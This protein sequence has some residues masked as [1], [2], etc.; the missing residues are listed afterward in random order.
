V[1]RIAA[2]LL[3]SG[4]LL[5]AATSL[6]PEA[7]QRTYANALL[8]RLPQGEWCSDSLQAKALGWFSRLD[9]NRAAWP[10]AETI[11][12]LTALGSQCAQQAASDVS[13]SAAEW[14]ELEACRLQSDWA[15]V[16][17]VADGIVQ[18]QPK[19]V[20][21][22][23]ALYEA[24]EAT[25]DVDGLQSAAKRLA[26]LRPQVAL[27]VTAGASEWM[28]AGYDLDEY[29]LAF[30][31]RLDMTLYWEKP[32]DSGA[33]TEVARLAADTVR[34]GNRILQAVSA[35]T[36]VLNGGFEQTVRV[37]AGSPYG[38]PEDRYQ[39]R[40]GSNVIPRGRS[41]IVAER[42]GTPTLCAELNNDVAESLS[43]LISPPR[44]AQPDEL[45][46]MGATVRDS[47]PGTRIGMLR[48]H[49]EDALRNAYVPVVATSERWTTFAGV[50]PVEG[51]TS[52][53]RLQMLNQDEGHTLCIDNA[54]LVKVNA[55]DEARVQLGS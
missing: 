35:P 10:P 18:R 15:C 29:A 14:S 4:L 44:P 19:Q 55:P 24:A 3:I 48:L 27:A 43:G 8:M 12:R 36:L 53:I 23:F 34:V 9:E 51:N 25:G 30:E 28:L 50:L 21:A 20:A 40:S 13:L 42:E 2:V 38:F 26:T 6:M 46:L 33:A 54:F 32:A 45:Y 22:L 31:D 37:H 1:K 52:T 16:K 49:P 41:V 11:E 39:S 5:V 17:A 7:L 47:G